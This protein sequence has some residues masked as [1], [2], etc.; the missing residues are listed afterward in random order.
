M[1]EQQ[2][3][4]QQIGEQQPAAQQP[5][6]FYDGNPAFRVDY[7]NKS[8]RFMAQLGWN[9]QHGVG[10]SSGY[11]QGRRHC[12]IQHSRACDD[13]DAGRRVQRVVTIG[14]VRGVPAGMHCLRLLRIQR[15]D[16][17]F[18]QFLQQA[19]R[20]STRTAARPLAKWSRAWRI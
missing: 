16:S 11:T 10:Q 5:L 1:G 14:S 13:G 7:R 17:A 20:V 19:T 2:P 4:A 12:R 3:T 18:H 8:Y 6:R 15:L 9:L